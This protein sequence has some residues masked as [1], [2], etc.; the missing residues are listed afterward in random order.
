MINLN[1]SQNQ[2]SDFV[3][4]TNN[5]FLPLKHFVNK[6]KNL[7]LLLINL[8]IKINFFHF[9]FFLELMKKLLRMLFIQKKLN[10]L[11]KKNQ[12]HKFVIFHFLKLI[13]KNLE[14]KYTVG[15]F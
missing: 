6:K 1:L 15:N 3:N 10:L 2:Y 7:S 14:K 5:V 12:L 11:Y 4:L 8:D 9:Q 13:K